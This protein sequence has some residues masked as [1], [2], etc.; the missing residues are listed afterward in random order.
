MKKLI[1]ILMGVT[2]AWA[3]FKCQEAH[4]DKW[5]R[6]GIL[7]PGHYL[8]CVMYGTEPGVCYM[9]ICAGTLAETDEQINI[10]NADPITPPGIVEFYHWDS[11]YWIKYKVPWKYID[12]E[13]M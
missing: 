12:G 5:V 10:L 3:L 2:M 1:L 6:T 13:I 7:D 9:T 11:G 8:I 4:A